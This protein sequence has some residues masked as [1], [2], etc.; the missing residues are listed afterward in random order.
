MDDDAS[1]RLTRRRLLG[2]TATIGVASASA[3]VGTMAYFSD[4]VSSDEN[5]IEAGTMELHLFGGTSGGDG[6]NGE[7]VMQAAKPGDEIPGEITLTNQGTIEADHVQLAFDFEEPEGMVERFRIDQLVYGS[8]GSTID[9]TDGLNDA[10]GNGILDLKDLTAEANS[11]ALD[12]LTPPPERGGGS[13]RL[14]LIFAWDTDQPDN[15][16]YMGEEFTMTVRFALHQDKSQD[17]DGESSD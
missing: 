10:N 16:A 12:D 4:S 14:E 11:D 5:R 8:T 6:G 17:I 13:E 9:I 15:S 1:V 2:A 3:G 7:W